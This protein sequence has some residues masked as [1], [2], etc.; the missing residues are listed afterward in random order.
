MS[1]KKGGKR[2]KFNPLTQC[3]SKTSNKVSIIKN[4]KHTQN[5]MIECS[6]MLKILCNCLDFEVGLVG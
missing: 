2:L 4:L 1:E 6:L 3:T 5:G